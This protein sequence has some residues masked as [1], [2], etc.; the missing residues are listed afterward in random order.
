MY[1][2]DF[3]N[4]IFNH[5]G[6]IIPTQ[7][8]KLEKYGYIED[9]YIVYSYNNKDNLIYYSNL[10]LDNYIIDFSIDKNILR[11]IISV[12]LHYDILKSLYDIEL[13]LIVK[14]Q[15]QSLEYNHRNYINININIKSNFIVL[16]IFEFN[17]IFIFISLILVVIPLGL[18][19]YYN[20]DIESDIFW[21]LYPTAR[22]LC[23]SVKNK[24][25]ID[26]Y[27]EIYQCTY[28]YYKWIT[29]RGIQLLFNKIDKNK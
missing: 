22:V 23:H 17:N 16:D 20:E 19:F 27:N 12:L 15:L 28:Y 24:S 6:L 7:D 13:D 18:W 21:E 2:L 29:L 26:L 3:N 8:T 25:D 11:P 5:F 10:I 14:D 9:G 4:A 1:K